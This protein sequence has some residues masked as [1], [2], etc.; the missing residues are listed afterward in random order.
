MNAQIQI[1]SAVD[2]LLWG[3]IVQD[4]NA[5]R[6]ACLQCFCT[7][8]AGISET[9]LVLNSI[10]D[11]GASVRL[12]HLIGQRFDDL[13]AAIGPEG[14]FAE[15]GKIAFK[16]LEAFRTQEGLRT[17]L[18]HGVARIS[19]ERSGKWVLVFRQLSIRARQSDRT[20]LLME[21]DEGIETLA[22]IKRKSQHLCS[23][24]GNLRK[25]LVC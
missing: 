10:A 9:L 18:A 1:E 23:V 14:V 4:V 5:W 7:A 2:D 17:Y 13:A 16:A 15:E 25:Q 3:R 8:E 6:G 12:R 11:K 19:V 22:E 21:E 24:L 20:M